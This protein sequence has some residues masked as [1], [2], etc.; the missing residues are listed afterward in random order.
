[1]IDLAAARHNLREVRRLTGPGVGIWPA[2]KAN[3]YGH[4]A[5]PIS[6]ALADEGATG[7]CVAT[8][9][10]AAEISSSGATMGRPVLLLGGVGPGDEEAIVASGAEVSVADASQAARLSQASARAAQVTRVH[11]KVDTGMGR[12]GVR[13]EDAARVAL[14]IEK[15]PSLRLAALMTHFATSDSSHSHAREQLARLL[16]AASGTR[17][18][19]GR[20]LALHSANSGA[21]LS[22]PESHLS[23]VRPGIML[24]GSFPSP[25]CQKTAD[26]RP[27]MTLCSRIVFVKDVLPGESVSYGRAWTAS[28]PSRIATVSIGYGDGLPR[29]LSN[30]GRALVRGQL[31]PIAGRVCMDQTMLD[32][33]GIEGAA[34][35]DDVVFW[36]VQRGVEL[37]VED[38]AEQIGAIPYELTCTAAP[39]VRRVCTS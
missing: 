31:A 23:F 22:L 2:V 29:R 35:G 28:R 16:R 18:L 6:R 39:R 21:V 14:E 8:V 9:D 10:E 30:G 25:D 4:G 19:I 3:A 17:A 32:V 36:G 33:T 24:Y 37:K 7:F 1:M 12:I 13:P 20:E 27:V 15:M 38:V 5:I 34:V 11:L 26:L